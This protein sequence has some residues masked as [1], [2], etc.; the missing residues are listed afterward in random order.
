MSAGVS[1]NPRSFMVSK[2]VYASLSAVG[3]DLNEVDVFDQPV[4]EVR[5]GGAGSSSGKCS[6]MSSKRATMLATIPADPCRRTPAFVERLHARSSL[7]NIQ[8]EGPDP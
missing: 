2:I 6:S 4:G 1:E 5:Q 8:I 7:F 3:G